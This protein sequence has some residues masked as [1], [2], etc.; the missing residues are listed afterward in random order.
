MTLTCYL[1]TRRVIVSRRIAII[2]ETV[3]AG[4]LRGAQVREIATCAG[5]S[6]PAGESYD[7]DRARQRECRH[8]ARQ[9][10]ARSGHRAP[11]FSYAENRSSLEVPWPAGICRNLAPGPSQMHQ[12]HSITFRVELVSP[13]SRKISA[14]ECRTAQHLPALVG[15]FR[16]APKDLSPL[17]LHDG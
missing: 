6:E 2:E 12:Q 13:G 10:C 15:S 9:P 5:S 7:S 4:N 16:E 17:L 8:P 1:V 14:Y 3:P 11:P